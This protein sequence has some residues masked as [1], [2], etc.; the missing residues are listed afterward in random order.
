MNPK[1][2]RKEISLALKN[3]NQHFRC[4][5]VVSK[6]FIIT[7]FSNF[8]LFFFFLQLYLSFCRESDKFDE[9]Q[10]EKQF[11]EYCKLEWK[12]MAEKDKVCWIK[13]AQEEEDQY[14]VNNF[15]INVLPYLKN[16]CR[17]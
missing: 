2:E 16:Y 3:Q 7:E 14:R 17:F 8:C 5:N 13:A 15:I 4:V 6:T 12:N 10:D 11:N 1:R 9:N